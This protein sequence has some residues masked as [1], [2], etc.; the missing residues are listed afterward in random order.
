M[1]TLRVKRF[2]ELALYHTVFQIK[3]VCFNPEIQDQAEKDFLEKVPDDC[4]DILGSRISVKS[5]YLA[6]F[7]R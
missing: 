2:V 4:V 6:S 1:Y 3:F 5:L 7:L